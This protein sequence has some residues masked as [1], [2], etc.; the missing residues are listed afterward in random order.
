MN[1]KIVLENILNLTKSLT[2][3]Y[4]YSTIESSNE[5]SRSV[6]H[7]GLLDNLEMQDEIYQNM[8]DDGMYTIENVS[9]SAIKKIY[10]KLTKDEA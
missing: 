4:M 7:Q 1:N 10:K 8:K 2:S 3:L 9:S 5:T 6:F